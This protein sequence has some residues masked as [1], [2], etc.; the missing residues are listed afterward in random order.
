MF[1]WFTV[2]A[3]IRRPRFHAGAGSALTRAALA[4]WLGLVAGLL[5]GGCETIEP[6]VKI[7]ARIAYMEAEALENDELYTEAAEKFQQVAD[8]NPGTLLGSF[9]YL[10]LGENNYISEKWEEAEINYKLFLTTNQNSHLTSYVLYRLI[11]VQHELG[12]TGFFSNTRDI[13]RNMEPNRR[14]IQD[15]QRF[16]F[17]FPQSIFM[18]QVKEYFR[19]SRDALAAHEHLVADFYFGK[20][21]FNAAASRYLYLLRKFP[22]YSQSEVVLERLIESYRNNRQ[23]GLAEEMER[24]RRPRPQGAA[25]T[26]AQGT[27]ISRA[28]PTAR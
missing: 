2:S 16:F 15:Y 13:E 12:F 26:G 10:R 27:G 14:V 4:V 28:A 25:L 23:L 8:E 24:L 7:P 5:A 18:D 6:K 11:S 3:P 21:Q 17:L 22:R 1:Q 20:G 9:A 19:S